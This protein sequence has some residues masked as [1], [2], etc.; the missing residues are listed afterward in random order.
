MLPL[1]T[2]GT[3]IYAPTRTPTA[4]ELDNCEHYDLT[5]DNTWDPHNVHLSQVHTSTDILHSHYTAHLFC[6]LDQTIN[7]DYR[8]LG[9]ISAL[10]DHRTI[11]ATN[12][13]LSDI[14]ISPSAALDVPLP[15]TFISTKRH[16]DVTPDDL[17]NRWM[18][19][20]EQAKST[21]NATTQHYVRSAL[22]P[23]SRRYRTDRYFYRNRLASTFAADIYHGRCASARGNKYCFI[24]AHPNGFCVAYPQKTKTSNKTTESLQSMTRDWGIPHKLIVDGA[25][26]MIGDK[27]TFRAKMKYHDIKLHVS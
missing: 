18:I 19:G 22:L 1:H 17:A 4:Y 25:Q 15:H 10:M 26:E 27:T 5:S 14:K 2:K 24:V 21:L 20:I 7:D 9:D 11:S 23:L 12:E 6:E 16:T 13:H 8:I 3:L